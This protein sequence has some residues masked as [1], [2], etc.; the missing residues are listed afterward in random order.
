[1]ND[2]GFGLGVFFTTWVRYSV[3]VTILSSS[4]GI[5]VEFIHSRRRHRP[6]RRRRRRRRRRHGL[7]T[8]MM[9][10]T[11]TLW[12]SLVFRLHFGVDNSNESGLGT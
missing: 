1:M 6:R 12:R 4:S 9:T 8:M 3:T 7:K 5:F 2:F 10:K 11:T